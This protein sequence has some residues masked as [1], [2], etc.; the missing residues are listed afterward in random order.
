MA[1]GFISDQANYSHILIDEMLDAGNDVS[2]IIKNCTYFNVIQMENKN[3][4]SV[5]RKINNEFIE[6]RRE[7]KDLRN[8]KCNLKI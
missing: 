3:V 5:L 4:N 6:S 1:N 7:L 8:K 2:D